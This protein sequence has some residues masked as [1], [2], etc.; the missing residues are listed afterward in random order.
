MTFGRNKIK[1][2]EKAARPREIAGNDQRF[3]EILTELGESG[4][5]SVLVR[6]SP[7]SSSSS[8]SLNERVVP[9]AY[10]ACTWQAYA[11]RA[12]ASHLDGLGDEVTAGCAVTS[13]PARGH[14]VW[15]RAAGASESQPES[16]TVER[17]EREDLSREENPPEAGEGERWIEGDEGREGMR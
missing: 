17:G 13:R 5:R 7:S 16:G 15:E 12:H 3:P 1:Q 9:R 2:H 11:V 4:Q 14:R 6:A 8:S 10:D